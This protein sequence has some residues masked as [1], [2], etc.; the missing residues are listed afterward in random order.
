MSDSDGSP[1]RYNRHHRRSRSRSPVA[2]GCVGETPVKC[3]ARQL[4]EA[5]VP[6]E[7]LAKQPQAAPDDPE[8]P[9]PEPV[10]ARKAAPAAR[11]AAP[12]APPRPAPPRMNQGA[13]AAALASH[14]TAPGTLPARGQ[15]PCVP[16]R[17]RRGPPGLQRKAQSVPSTA[18]TPSPA[19]PRPAPKPYPPKAA[20]PEGRLRP[21]RPQTPKRTPPGITLPQLQRRVF[22]EGR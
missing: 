5:A 1:Q 22:Q 20:F 8:P 17:P 3:D 19:T 15:A 7:L 9:A 13:A 6:V 14:A 12:A 4:P 11:A 16:R 10:P 21:V 18:P 2:P